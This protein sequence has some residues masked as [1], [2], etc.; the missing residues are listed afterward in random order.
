M[1]TTENLPSLQEEIRSRLRAFPAL[2]RS[3]RAASRGRADA[4]R[5][6][7][8]E[9][10]AAA[11]PDPDRDLAGLEEKTARFRCDLARGHVA[12]VRE[13]HRAA[14]L[15]LEEWT[16][17]VANELPELPCKNWAWR[18]GAP[19][20]MARERRC[21]S[22]RAIDGV[23]Y[24]CARELGHDGACE[25]DRSRIAARALLRECSRGLPGMAPCLRLHGH[26][27]RCSSRRP[28]RWDRS[29]PC[30]LCTLHEAGTSV[31]WHGGRER[32]QR[33]RFDAVRACGTRSILATCGVCGTARRPAPELC[34]V[35]RV[36]ERCDV[37]GAIRR[38]ARFG[39]ARGRSFIDGHRYGL[40]RKLRKGGR[41][42]EKMLTLTIP[43]ASAEDASGEVARAAR[44]TL[45]A[46]V[47]AL[48]LA[49]PRF[50]RRLNAHWRDRSESRV[51]YHRAFEWTPGRSDEH[52]HPHFHVYLWSPWVDAAAL[53]S[54]W[55]EAL[56]E[57]G[58]PVEDD[59]DGAPRVRIKLQI[60]RSFNVAAACE[61]VKGGRRSALTLSRIEFVEPAAGA[62]FRRGPRA[63]EHVGPGI[64]AFKYAEGWTLGDVAECSDDVRARLYMA[65][66]GKRL[67]QAARSFFLEDARAC[68]AECGASHFRIAFEATLA[69]VELDAGRVAEARAPP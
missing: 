3:F 69:F 23:S 10:L 58:W 42:T 15:A 5:A 45:H 37:Q 28:K 59:A 32:G 17:I 47:L 53:R 56:R 62:E 22:V 14:R 33:D 41:F 25:V 55:A 44:D 6:A 9:P 38:R 2:R 61:L 11:L 7:T 48:F 60:L 29:C 63:G 8:A 65:L 18:A 4:V 19:R 1:D 30:S 12:R 51:T 21:S 27:G 31:L 36:C 16:T 13:I 34:G 57:S 20:P 50:L 68:C 39:R 49:W 26:R 24:R 46:R 40:A 35:R 64:D 43:H 52:G 66:E 54:W 67:T